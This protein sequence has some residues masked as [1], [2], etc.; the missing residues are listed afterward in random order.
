MKKSVASRPN[1]GAHILHQY[2]LQLSIHSW[3]VSDFKFTIHYFVISFRKLINTS[4][5]RSHSISFSTHHDSRSSMSIINA[6]QCTALDTVKLLVNIFPVLANAT[7]I[8]E[9]W[10]PVGNCNPYSKIVGNHAPCFDF[11]VVGAGSA[12]C[13]IAARLSEVPYWNVSNQAKEDCPAVRDLRI[14]TLAQSD[15]LFPYRS[16]CW[17]PEASN[18]RSRRSQE[19]RRTYT[20]NCTTGAINRNPITSAAK[21]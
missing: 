10:W 9:E 3:H 5:H 6:T 11:I 18:L 17:K 19:P 16:C 8:A 15:V 14:Y 12:G 2:R 4:R 20:T 7:P 1:Q 13:A 21:R